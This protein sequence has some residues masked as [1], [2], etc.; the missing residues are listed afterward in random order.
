MWKAMRDHLYRSEALPT[1]PTEKKVLPYFVID[2]FNKLY[3]WQQ[4]DPVNETA[5]VTFRHPEKGVLSMTV[6]FHSPTSLV[7]NIG[8]NTLFRNYKLTADAYQ[9]LFGFYNSIG[10]AELAHDWGKEA[11]TTHSLVVDEKE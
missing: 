9:F 1:P 5:T 10:R 8:S 4:T 3:R 2:I 7:I 6:T 11:M